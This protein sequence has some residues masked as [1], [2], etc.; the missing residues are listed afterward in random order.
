MEVVDAGVGGDADLAA[1]ALDDA[2]A[3][4]QAD[5]GAARA[6][7]SAAAVVARKDAFAVGRGDGRARALDGASAGAVLEGGVDADRAGLARAVA[8]CVEEKVGEDRADQRFVAACVGEL[9]DLQ[10]GAAGP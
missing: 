9:A 6:A 8:Q 5:A 7:F 1:V 3:D 10:V 2:P 4:R